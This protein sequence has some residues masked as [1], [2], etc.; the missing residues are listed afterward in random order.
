VHV[1]S[2]RT[3]VGRILLFT[4]T[5]SGYLTGN[6][7]DSLLEVVFLT[8]KAAQK[9]EWSFIA[10]SVRFYIFFSIVSFFFPLHHAW[11]PAAPRLKQ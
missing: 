5:G 8:K 4:S 7:W 2:K 1:R 6:N 9:I 3:T 10:V 11:S